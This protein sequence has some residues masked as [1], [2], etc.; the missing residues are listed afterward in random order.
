MTYDANALKDMAGAVRADALRA[1]LC[2]RSGHAGI[3]LGAADIITAMNPIL[4]FSK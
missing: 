2:A 1:L 4:L 3:V